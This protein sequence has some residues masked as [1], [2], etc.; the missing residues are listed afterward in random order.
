MTRMGISQI[1]LSA[2]KPIQT[3]EE[4]HAA[5]ALI[6]SADLDQMDT[7]NR[8]LYETLLVLTEAFDA[9]FETP[10]PTPAELLQIMM[11]A[12]HKTQAEIAAIVGTKQ[13]NISH[14]LHGRRAITN[15]QDAC[16]T[17]YFKMRRGAFLPTKSTG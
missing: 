15:E 13:P 12:T 3:V 1:P 17:A 10:E 6:E 7:L 14:I 16:L 4:L 2:I 9:Q 5:V 8:N 11:D